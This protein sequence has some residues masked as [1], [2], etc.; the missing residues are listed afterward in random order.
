MTGP[1]TSEAAST[2]PHVHPAAATAS[3]SGSVDNSTSRKRD[4][5]LDSMRAQPSRLVVVTGTGVTLASVGF[6]GPGTEVAGWHGL[7][8]DG[9]NRC[10]RLNLIDAED[11]SILAHLLTAKKC[12]WFIHAA[13]KIHECLAN[14]INER[15]AWMK[16]SVGSLKVKDPRLIKAILAL[17]GLVSTLNYDDT[18]YQVSKRTPLHWQQQKEINRRLRS[19]ASDF[20]LH[21]HGVYDD[22]NS[23]VLDRS[24]YQKISTDTKM[25]GLLQGFARDKTLL[26]IGCRN[27]FLDPNLQTLL[28]W[29]KMGLVG[30]DLRHFILCRASEESDIVNE[31]RPHGYVTPLV[32]GDD[33]SDLAPFLEQLATDARGAA[34][35]V[36]PPTLPPAPIN[37][38]KPA[39]IWTLHSAP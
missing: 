15:E 13:E 3:A 12:E 18:I 32:Y 22:V 26:F 5:L 38:R 6:P 28:T 23:I 14:N 17:G 24:S 16:D 8:T 30:L 4:E 35:T 29:A 2:E 9:L 39:D 36:N 10:K 21:L 34:A 19:Y 27:T 11:A 7:L 20:T 37:A 33:H 25:Q 1:A 31:L